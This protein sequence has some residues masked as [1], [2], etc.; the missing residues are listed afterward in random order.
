M[1]AT[2]WLEKPRRDVAGERA[3]LSRGLSSPTNCPP[4][5]LQTGTLE[6]KESMCLVQVPVVI[7]WLKQEPDPDLPHFPPSHNILLL[8][9]EESALSWL[10]HSLLHSFITPKLFPH[11]LSR[12]VGVQH[13]LCLFVCNL[14]LTLLQQ[15]SEAAYKDTRS[16]IKYHEMRGEGWKEKGPTLEQLGK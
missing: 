12:E 15:N 4:T 1:K 13:P 7:N 2:G 10:V 8:L 11:S 16:I 6:A 9:W 14:Y 5:V 3:T